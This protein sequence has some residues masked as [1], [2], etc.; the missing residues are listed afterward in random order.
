VVLLPHANHDPSPQHHAGRNHATAPV[1]AARQ[2]HDAELAMKMARHSFDSWLTASD[3]DPRSLANMHA[4]RTRTAVHEAARAIATLLDTLDAEATEL[5]T[6]SAQDT[7]V[8]VP[9]TQECAGKV[10]GPHSRA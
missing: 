9:G 3:Q 10:A 8:P 5:T 1:S 7:D 4:D 6:I 2:W